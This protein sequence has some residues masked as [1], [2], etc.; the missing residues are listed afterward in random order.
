MKSY[1]VKLKVKEQ[2]ISHYTDIQVNAETE[3]EA[4]KIAIEK[5]NGMGEDELNDIAYY[6]DDDF[7]FETIRISPD[8]A[9]NIEPNED[10]VEGVR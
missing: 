10:W 1:C 9:Q 7:Y 5:V 2:I 4:E 3:E 8:C 6:E